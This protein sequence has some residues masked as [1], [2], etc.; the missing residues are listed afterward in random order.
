MFPLHRKIIQNF[1]TDDI[2]DINTYGGYKGAY[3]LKITTRNM[4]LAEK[5]AS[6]CESLDGEAVI[7]E[8]KNLLNFEVYCIAED[9]SM[10]TLKIK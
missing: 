2:K 3:I 10:Y 6:Y 4:V 9:T 5:I 7:K 1:I 8:N